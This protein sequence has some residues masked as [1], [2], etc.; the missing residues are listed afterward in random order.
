M[1]KAMF[2]VGL[3]FATNVVAGLQDSADRASKSMNDSLRAA[4]GASGAI[5]G[6]SI[7]GRGIKNSFVSLKDIDDAASDKV[8]NYGCTALY[9]AFVASAALQS[10]SEE[11]K[12]N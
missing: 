12:T 2:V 5:M 9:A 7:I 8:I 10:N 6:C 11:K 3:F 4:V 1:K